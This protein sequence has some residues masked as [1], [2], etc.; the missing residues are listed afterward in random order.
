VAEFNITSGDTLPRI[1]TTITD[2]DGNA[3]DIEDC[4]VTFAL[5]PIQSGESH[6]I[7]EALFSAAATNDQVTDGSDGTKGKAHYDWVP[8]DTDTP[9]GYVAQW[10]IAFD[11]EPMS[12]PNDGA[13]D[14]VAIFPALAEVTS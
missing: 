11:G 7:G 14:T 6:R 9:G 4:D 13:Y 10:R 1:E 8:G 2:G 5:A 12:A 3:V